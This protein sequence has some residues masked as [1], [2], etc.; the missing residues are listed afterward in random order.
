MPTTVPIKALCLGDIDE[1]PRA[2][3]TLDDRTIATYAAQYRSDDLPDPTP[4]S[5][6]I[7]R[8]RLK[9]WDGIHRVRGAILAGR[10]TI[11]A[12][13]RTGRRRD[14]VWRLCDGHRKDYQ[15]RSEEDQMLATMLLVRDPYHRKKTDE[16]LA[17]HLNVPIEMVEN[18]RDATL[19]P[20]GRLAVPGILDPNTSEARSCLK[21]LSD[22]LSTH[23]EYEY[24]EPLLRE[25][26]YILEE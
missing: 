6:M 8:N 24:L 12:E 26:R 20:Q 2:R 23:R 1:I 17:N 19:P 10:D 13:C 16:H 21:T 7:T 14:Y 3:M 22:L 5:V 25:I 4:I 15:D 18:A 9:V 11:Q